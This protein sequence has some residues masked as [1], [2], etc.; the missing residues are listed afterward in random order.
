MARKKTALFNFKRF[1]LIQKL[2]LI[3][4]LMFFFLGSL[5]HIHFINDAE[6]ITLGIF[7]LE[8]YDD[9][10]HYGSGVWALFAALMSTRASIFYFKLFGLIYG[11]DGVLGLVLGQGYLDAGIF[12]KGPTTLPWDFKFM[13][14][15]PHITIGFFAAFAGFVLSKN[16]KAK[17]R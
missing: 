11:F 9:L 17:N 6:G 12:I 7:K 14:N 1:T 10:L 3:Y 13:A 2:A 4:A 15:I 8:W 5:R 16:E